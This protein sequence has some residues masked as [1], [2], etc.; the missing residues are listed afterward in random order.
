MAMKI[1][2]NVDKY[3]NLAA[4]LGL[5][6]SDFKDSIFLLFFFLF[7]P[8][9]YILGF[10]SQF[11]N[12]TFVIFFVSWIIF[13]LSKKYINS[14]FE[15]SLPKS[16]LFY[17]PLATFLFVLISFLI[18]P[19]KAWAFFAN[20]TLTDS[21]AFIALAV[22][23][24]VLLVSYEKVDIKQVNK[25]FITSFSIAFFVM[26][27][28]LILGKRVDFTIFGGVKELLVILLVISSLSVLSI[29]DTDNLYKKIAKFIFP[30]FSILFAAAA[31]I[32]EIWILYFITYAILAF[33]NYNKK[34]PLQS[35]FIFSAIASIL[36]AVYLLFGKAL[37]LPVKFVYLSP[38]FFDSLTLLNNEYSYSFLYKLFGMG[39]ASYAFAW[40][41]FKPSINYNLGDLWRAD[42]YVAPNLLIQ[43]AVDFGVFASF[44][45][46]ATILAVIIFFFK[47]LFNSGFA[48]KASSSLVSLYIVL[49][50]LALSFV[51]NS[52]SLASTIL[53]VFYLAAFI[54]ELKDKSLLKDT[55]IRVKKKI[56]RILIAAPFALLALVMLYASFAAASSFVLMQAAS[57]ALNNNNTKL[58]RTLVDFQAF[59]SPIKDSAYLSKAQLHQ[60]EINKILQNLKNKKNKA[61]RSQI[62]TLYDKI[63]ESFEKAAKYS[64]NNYKNW[65][66]LSSAYLAH[67][68]LSNDEE[69]YKKAKEAADKA[70]VLAPWNPAVYVQYAKLYSYKKDKVQDVKNNLI[71]ALRLNPQDAVVYGNLWTLFV[72]EQDFDSAIALSQEMMR[73][74]GADPRL[75]YDLAY[76]HFLKKDYKAAEQYLSLLLKNNI[77]SYDVL[78]V[79][80]NVEL[81]L[82]KEDELRSYLNSLAE[83]GNKQI[84]E[85]AKRILKE[86]EQLN[87][88]KSLEKAKDD[89]ESDAN[90]ETDSNND[91]ADQR[92]DVKDSGTK[93]DSENN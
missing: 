1:F 18:N 31:N 77:L 6:L 72:A 70:R 35:S 67:Y 47:F 80:A 88:K 9:S 22:S 87:L 59:I 60:I 21:F 37:Q 29:K 24:F 10:N 11:L 33:V 12:Y 64:P 41:L 68:D 81:A 66:D 15:I 8:V 53:F 52:A 17:A 44:A 36:S 30:V 42:F 58:A 71:V 26:I 23:L 73:V 50:I 56:Y 65:L 2:K 62:L 19:G 43:Y 89:K 90:K 7:L 3:K 54:N 63:I 5:S 48:R 14:D 57:V 16:L 61:A 75:V 49:F 92:L 25:G 40:Q 34:R 93:T 78:L 69:K 79:W 91:E 55:L 4:D 39:P 45:L 20:L 13:K 82:N 32:Y 85:A 84:K 51:F 86:L 28:S 46:L 38:G 83:K 27:V 74:Y 76:A